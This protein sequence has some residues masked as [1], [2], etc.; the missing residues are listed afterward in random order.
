MSDIPTKYRVVDFISKLL[1]IY[2]F[3]QQNDI[4]CARSL[5]DG[6]LI[7][8]HVEGDV[9]PEVKNLVDFKY[10]SDEHVT[11]Y[12]QGDL[13]RKTEV[14]CIFLATVAVAKYIEFRSIPSQKLN[15][16]SYEHLYNHFIVKTGESLCME[17]GE[18]NVMRDIMAFFGKEATS[19]AIKKG[20]GL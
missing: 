7:H 5:I 18:Q 11:V 9:D 12:W 14:N 1:P 15:I 19:E 3:E 16:E 17:P 2:T 10:Y 4:T 20:I 6:T 13:N 8:P